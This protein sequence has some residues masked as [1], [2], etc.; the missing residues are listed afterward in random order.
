MTVHGCEPCQVQI[1]GVPHAI[2]LLD[3]RADPRTH[4][5]ILEVKVA[6]KNPSGRHYIGRFR[7]EADRLHADGA[8]RAIETMEWVIRANLPPTARELSLET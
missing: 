5:A 6:A 8:A 3:I 1:D 4:G 7:I 2:W